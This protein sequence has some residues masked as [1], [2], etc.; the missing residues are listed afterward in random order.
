M[1]VPAQHR[2]QRLH[3]GHPVPQRDDVPDAEHQ[4]R[5]AEVVPVAD[6]GAV[7]AESRTS[8]STPTGM[9]SSPAYAPA[10][11]LVM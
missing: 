9:C 4:R 6:P 3:E 1:P 10:Y 7:P 11:R 8:G 2:R 5:V